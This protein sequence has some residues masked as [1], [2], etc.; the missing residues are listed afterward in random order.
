VTTAKRT[1]TADATKQARALLGSL[2]RHE[3]H[4]AYRQSFRDLGQELAK[5]IEARTGPLRKAFGLVSTP[6]DADYLTR[7]MLDVL[8]RAKA[9]LACYW[10]DRRT[11]D[12]GDVATVIQAFEDP[13]LISGRVETI[14]VAK[15]IISSSCIV[16]TNL[17][18]LLSKVNPVR[19]VIAAPV[20][21]RGA[22][23]ILRKAFPDSISSRFEF[24]TF[25]I[26]S[27][28]RGSIV[29]PGVGGMVEE[30]LGLAGKS[31]RFVPAL[32]SE[33]RN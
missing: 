18:K 3:G 9:R 32:V 28:R 17:E 24:V 20:M 2:V 1:F 27:Q 21:L 25:A 8:P 26:D 15:A 19:V 16:R 10:T 13:R 33:W 23:A 31:R 22:D 6:E 4:A 30:R 11:F 12:D 29:V 7:G 5:A 14:I